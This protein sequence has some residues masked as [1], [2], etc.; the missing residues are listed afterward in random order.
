MSDVLS[1]PAGLAI[2]VL[3]VL[4]AATLFAWT[5]VLLVVKPSSELA[6]RLAPYGAAHD[7]EDDELFDGVGIKL[8]KTELV[9][10]AVLGA[11]KL[12]IG[13]TVV[14]WLERRLDQANVPLRAAEALFAYAAAAALASLLAL[15]TIGPI[16]ALGL[17]GLLT[18][19]PLAMLSFRARQRRVHF[20][21]QLPDALKLLSGTL[22]AGFS[23]LQG[24]ETIAGEVGEPMGQELQRVLAEARLG[25]PLED[26]LGDMA[27]RL[28]SADFEWTVMAIGIQREVGGNLAE[29]LDTVAETML[30]RQRLRREVKALTAEGRMSAIIIGILPPSLGAFMYVVN[31]EYISALTTTT[32][33][34]A[35][36]VMSGL[37]AAGGF[38]WMKKV[39]EIE[40]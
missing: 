36:A 26:A 37:L 10:R 15:L 6:T 35:L 25:R 33:G 16:I 28:E 3:L 13:R 29:L 12:T 1:G 23:L 27:T 7:G 32:L 17:V 19:T 2:I 30:A 4:A 18:V 38:W 22:R 8:V 34:Q 39:I 9:R 24:V 5:I 11:S 21:G 40:V 14:T 20:T 31:R